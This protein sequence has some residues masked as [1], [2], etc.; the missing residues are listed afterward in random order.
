MSTYKENLVSLLPYGSNAKK[1]KAKRDDK[2]RTVV[3]VKTGKKNGKAVY[4]TYRF[5]EEAGV[6]L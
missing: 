1:L 2:G 5:D 3:T 6:I 4:K